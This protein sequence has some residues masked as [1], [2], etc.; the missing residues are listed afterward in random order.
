MNEAKLP[1]SDFPFV[2]HS[3]VCVGSVIHDQQIPARVPN[4]AVL[5]ILSLLLGKLVAVG[6]PDAVLLF[7]LTF[8]FGLC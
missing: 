6:I 5:E 7:L 1:M 4:L 2:E 8:R 3:E